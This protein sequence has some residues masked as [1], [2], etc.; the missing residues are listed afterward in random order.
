MHLKL[1]LHKLISGKLCVFLMYMYSWDMKIWCLSNLWCSILLPPHQQ[2]A[3]FF[4]VEKMERLWHDGLNSFSPG[5][6]TWTRCESINLN[7]L[8]S[9]KNFRCHTSLLCHEVGKAKRN[10]KFW[11]QTK[12]VCTGN[13]ILPNHGIVWEAIEQP[14]RSFPWSCTLYKFFMTKWLGRLTF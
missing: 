6:R 12:I 11:C 13:N 1:A 2:G 7:Y 3:Y 8:L 10:G 4:R 14:R 9:G 5:N